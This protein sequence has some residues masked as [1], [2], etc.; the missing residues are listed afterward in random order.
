MPEGP[1]VLF[2]SD[3]YMFCQ[4]IVDFL[5]G[6]LILSLDIPKGMLE[7]LWDGKLGLYRLVIVGFA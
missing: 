5:I 3:W 4:Q 6:T 2:R 7:F 1:N